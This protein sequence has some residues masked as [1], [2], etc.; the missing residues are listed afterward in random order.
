LAEVEAVLQSDLLK[1]RNASY[2]P[3][4]TLSLHSTDNT[5][6]HRSLL[7]SYSGTLLSEGEMCTISIGMSRE[8]RQVLRPGTVGGS[9]LPLIRRRRS[10]RRVKYSRE[11]SEGSVSSGPVMTISDLTMPDHCL[12]GS[13]VH[14]PQPVAFQMVV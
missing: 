3:Y 2:S 9:C 10:W 8:G 13:L 11:D 7:P 5:I 1:I 12:T 14:G 4:L 6:H